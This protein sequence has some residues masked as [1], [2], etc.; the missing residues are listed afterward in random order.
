L[1]EDKMGMAGAGFI[2]GLWNDQNRFFLIFFFVRLFN[3]K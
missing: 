1:P 3:I 2:S